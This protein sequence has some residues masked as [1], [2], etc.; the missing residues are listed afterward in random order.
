MM[1]SDVAWT[2]NDAFFVVTFCANYF[3]VISRLGQPLK[4][5][6]PAYAVQHFFVLEPEFPNV[7]LDDDAF[8]HITVTDVGFRCANL[9]VCRQAFSCRAIPGPLRCGMSPRSS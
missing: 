4:L 3:C 5:F 1:V 6:S 8:P 2:P 9:N 7:K